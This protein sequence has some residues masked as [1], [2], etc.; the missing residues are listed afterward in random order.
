MN[1]LGRGHQ[2][3]YFAE[4]NC[5]LKITN[6]SFSLRLIVLDHPLIEGEIS[7]NMGIAKAGTIIDTNYFYNPDRTWR[8]KIELIPLE[9]NSEHQLSHSDDLPIDSL[10]ECLLNMF[11]QDES[12]LLHSKQAKHPIPN[13]IVFENSNS[14]PSEYHFSTTN[15]CIA[16]FSS[17]NI[18]KNDMPSLF[19]LSLIHI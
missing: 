5:Q 16:R 17:D 8:V 9:E 19:I 14:I 2:N 18:Q 13:S 6:G 3:F 7:I 1:T 12:S 15:N 4:K 10:N 11:V